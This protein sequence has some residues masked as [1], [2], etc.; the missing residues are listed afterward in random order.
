MSDQNNSIKLPISQNGKSCTSE[1]GCNQ[2]YNGDTVYVEGINKSNLVT[3]YDNNTIQ[4][5]PF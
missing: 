3:I 4:Y 1:Y 5:I 2:L